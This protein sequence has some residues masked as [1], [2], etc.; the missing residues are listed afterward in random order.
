MYIYI[1]LLLYDANCVSLCLLYASEATGSAACDI[2]ATSAGS[3]SVVV[4]MPQAPVNIYT[5]TLRHILMRISCWL[6]SYVD[7][8]ALTSYHY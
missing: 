8:A 1:Q 5:G 3:I 2:M 6:L 7:L 4:M